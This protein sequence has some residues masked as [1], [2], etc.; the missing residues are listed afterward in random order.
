MKDQIPH[1]VKQERFQRLIDSMYEIF[2]KKNKADVGKVLEVLVEGTS[3]NNPE[4]LTGRTRGYKLVH[5]VGGKRN[6]GHLVNVRITGN[7]SFALE[8]EI[9]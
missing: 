1:E 5:F 2:Y 6:I 7:N 4:V 3:K 9:I 8:G